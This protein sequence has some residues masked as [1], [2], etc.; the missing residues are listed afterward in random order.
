MPGFRRRQFGRGGEK[1]IE[2]VEH[3]EVDDAGGEPAVPFGQAGDVARGVA[4]PVIGIAGVAV[5]VVVEIFRS[6]LDFAVPAEFGEFIHRPAPDGGIVAVEFCFEAL[7][8]VAP[9]HFPVSP[10][11]AVSGG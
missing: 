6:A 5:H 7:C 4:I 11:V 3:V 2:R 9:D 10:V 1:F 8:F